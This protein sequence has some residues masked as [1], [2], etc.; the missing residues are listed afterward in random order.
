MYVRFR[1]LVVNYLIGNDF[2]AETQYNSLQRIAEGGSPG[3][4]YADLATAFAESYQKEGSITK[5]CQAAQQFAKVNEQDILWPLGPS[6]YGEM[7]WGPDSEDICPFGDGD[8]L[9]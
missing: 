7:W 5:A 9:Q 2:A 4:M 3:K 1:M 8:R 6:A